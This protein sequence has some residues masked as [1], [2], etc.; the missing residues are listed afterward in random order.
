METSCRAVVRRH[1]G[2][3]NI[4][5][6]LV[7]HTVERMFEYVVICDDEK[8]NWIVKLG[9]TAKRSSEDVDSIPALI[10]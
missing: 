1:R 3:L 5:T 8:Q 9:K 2:D 10:L 7:H 4:I 6:I